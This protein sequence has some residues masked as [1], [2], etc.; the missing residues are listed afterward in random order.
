MRRSRRLLAGSLPPLPSRRRPRRWRRV[1]ERRREPL[2]GE[3]LPALGKRSDQALRSTSCSTTRTSRAI[4]RASPPTWS[5]CRTCSTSSTANGTLFTNDHTILISHTA[6]GIL[7]IAD[8]PLP[9]PDRADGLEHATATSRTTAARRSRR[10]SSTGRQPVDGADDSTPNMITDTGKT[11]PAPWVPFTR[12]GCD[13]GGVGTAN[14]ELEN[15]VD[16][17]RRRH[18][19]RLRAQLAGGDRSRPRSAPPTSSASR[20]TAPRP[21]RASARTTPTRRTTR[22][23]TSPAGTR[24]TRRSS[25][26]ST[27]TRRSPATRA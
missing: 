25:G 18:R 16:R 7:S 14:I 27:S 4:A 22:S 5:R 26:R 9:R 15:N 21:R 11:T 13:V 23:R 20:S 1:V 17:A 6:G 10:R 2:G 12:A 24:D 8:G 3:H 19:Q